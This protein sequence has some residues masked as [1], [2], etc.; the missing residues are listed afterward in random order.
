MG[1]EYHLECKDCIMT[2]NPFKYQSSGEYEYSIVGYIE[3]KHP[4]NCEE[5]VKDWT[6]FIISHSGHRICLID[7]LG[8]ESNPA[9]TTGAYL[10]GLTNK[11]GDKSFDKISPTDNFSGEKN[12][13]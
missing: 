5:Q 8:N 10:F 12:N 9:K 3:S 1:I 7:E 6:E 2:F 13:G 11:V 4:D